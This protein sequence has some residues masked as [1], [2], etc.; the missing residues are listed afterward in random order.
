MRNNPN[1]CTKCQHI[2]SDPSTDPC[3]TCVDGDAFEESDF[4]KQMK[5][6]MK[7]NAKQRTR[8]RCT[9]GRMC[10]CAPFEDVPPQLDP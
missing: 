5:Q 9:G 4:A 6:I 8:R 10:Y 1:I 2:R 7:E 3:F